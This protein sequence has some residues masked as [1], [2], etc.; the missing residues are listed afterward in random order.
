[1]IPRGAFGN[2]DEG[3]PPTSEVTLVL[4]SASVAVG[5]DSAVKSQEGTVCLRTQKS[6]KV[7]AVELKS[8]NPWSASAASNNRARPI[9]WARAGSSDRKCRGPI[10]GAA[11]HALA[12]GTTPH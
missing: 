6:L 10:G 12:P 8:L 11:H 9:T 4:G 3:A 7:W 5:Q 1:M 2:C